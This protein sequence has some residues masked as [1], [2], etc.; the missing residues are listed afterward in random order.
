M[1]GPEVLQ[2]LTKF[3]KGHMVLDR[4]EQDEAHRLAEGM[5]QFLKMVYCLVVKQWRYKLPQG[6]QHWLGS[7]HSWF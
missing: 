3:A 7:K 2:K 6:L 5:L 4:A 1:E